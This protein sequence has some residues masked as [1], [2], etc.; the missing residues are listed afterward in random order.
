MSRLDA[1]ADIIL[2]AIVRTIVEHFH[3]LRI[4]LFGSH[5]RGGAT[6]ES[7]YDLMIEVEDGNRA[8]I[9]LAVGE[10]LF[11]LDFD[12]DAVVTTPKAYAADRDD[13][14][15]LAYQIE[16]EGKL[17]YAR[18]GVSA[19]APPSPRGV[20]EPRPSRPQSVAMWVRRAENDFIGVGRMLGGSDPIADAVCFHAHQTAEK[21]LKAV[22]VRTGHAPPR[23]HRLGKLLK[24]CPPRLLRNKSVR[25][26]CAVLLVLYRYSRYVESREP[27]VDEARTALEAAGVVREAGRTLLG[28]L[29]A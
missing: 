28:L 27:T 1:P 23:T 4:V 10:H 22:I 20:R 12:V 19:A 29:P 3:P 6:E 9:E 15:L 21:Y 13:V 18:D 7:D 5:A 11:E 17:L 14:G 24:R 2:D 26:A 16:R 25:H 8:E